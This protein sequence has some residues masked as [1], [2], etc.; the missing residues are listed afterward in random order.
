MYKAANS[1]EDFSRVPYYIDLATQKQI[2]KV[3][4][5]KQ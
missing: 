3:K 4:S 1:F 2:A 5:R